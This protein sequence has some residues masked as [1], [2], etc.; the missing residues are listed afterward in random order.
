[1]LVV[2]VCLCIASI[3]CGVQCGNFVVTQKAAVC[4]AALASWLRGCLRYGLTAAWHLHQVSAET[5]A[6]RL[7]RRCGTQLHRSSGT[8]CALCWK[9]VPHELWQVTCT[10]LSLNFLCVCKQPTATCTGTPAAAIL[11]YVAATHTC[12]R[13]SVNALDVGCIMQEAHAPLLPA[14]RTWCPTPLSAVTP[15]FVHCAALSQSPKAG[16]RP[17]HAYTPRMLPC[18]SLG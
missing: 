2:F 13:L 1:M 5:R 8:Q 4:P 15:G 3:I 7:H 14:T 12:I 6:Q 11:C 16:C 9:A 10:R 18:H 17:K